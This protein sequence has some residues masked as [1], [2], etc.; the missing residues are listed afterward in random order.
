MKIIQKFFEYYLKPE[1]LYKGL[2]D[3]GIYLNKA[4]KNQN[5]FKLDLNEP[6]R[7]KWKDESEKQK[8]LLSN[9]RIY[10]KT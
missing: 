9:V 2:R 10:Y 7:G 6:S 4:L 3:G 1:Q 8:S 5:R